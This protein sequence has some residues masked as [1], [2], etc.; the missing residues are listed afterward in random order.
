[1]E[2]DKLVVCPR[3]RHRPERPSEAW[4]RDKLGHV[5][6]LPLHSL[7][8]QRERVCFHVRSAFKNSGSLSPLSLSLS[9]HAVKEVQ[10]CSPLTG[11]SQ[12][13]IPGLRQSPRKATGEREH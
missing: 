2:E 11:I 8:L 13:G 7:G 4:R 9:R 3:S 1:M 10:V 5:G 12:G 6:V